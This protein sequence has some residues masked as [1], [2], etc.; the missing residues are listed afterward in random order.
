MFIWVLWLVGTIFSNWIQDLYRI[1]G[2]VVKADVLE[3]C[4]MNYKE[5]SPTNGIEDVESNVT[6]D[7][8]SLPNYTTIVSYIVPVRIETEQVLDHPQ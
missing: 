5:T 8:M 4:V 1:E 2:V 7:G 6:F 3:I